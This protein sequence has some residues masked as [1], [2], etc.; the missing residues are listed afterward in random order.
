MERRAEPT[1]V[2]LAGFEKGADF[3]R[4][5]GRLGWQVALLAV[6]ALEHAASW[7]HPRMRD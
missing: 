7:P 3:R 2:Y 5:A 4:E 1:V 6:P